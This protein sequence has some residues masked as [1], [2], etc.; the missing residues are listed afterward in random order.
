MGNF[1]RESYNIFCITLI[2]TIL[3]VSIFSVYADDSNSSNITGNSTSTNITK[4]NVTKNAA[5]QPM[6]I[7]VSVTET[8]ST[9]NFG[10]LMADGVEHT[11]I[12]ATNV[13]VSAVGITA[14]LYVSASGDFKSGSNSIPLSNFKYTS[15]DSSSTTTKKSFTTSNE[16]VGTYA[17]LLVGSKTYH[18]NYFLTIPE[19]TEPGTYTT[20]ITYTAT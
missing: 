5:V 4:T 14:S 6:S 11:Y 19:G 16:L 15:P 20:K 13:T 18:M 17:Y 10:S 9:I 7:W 12:N 1:M 3:I 8:P 2:L